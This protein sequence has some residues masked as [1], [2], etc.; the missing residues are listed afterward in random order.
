MDTWRL[1]C[2]E[3]L[4]DGRT[5]G[6]FRAN[7]MKDYLET[8]VPFLERLELALRDMLEEEEAEITINPEVV[9]EDLTPVGGDIRIGKRLLRICGEA[10]PDMYAWTEA[11]LTAYLLVACGYCKPIERIQM[12]HPFSGRIWSY[13]PM[14]YQKPKYLYEHLWKVW[15]AKN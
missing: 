8:C 14:D 7:A 11:W 5:A 4:A 12:L 2:L 3:Q 1:A 9:P 13:G 15:K 6:L 10:R